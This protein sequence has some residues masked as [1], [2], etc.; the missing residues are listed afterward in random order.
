MT[1]AYAHIIPFA[2]WIILM[3][4]LGWAGLPPTW[5]Y[6]LRT[7]ACA[8][9][10]YKFRPW[11][12]YKKSDFLHLPLSIS[13]GVAVWFLWIFFE[14]DWCPPGLSDFYV[15]WA[16]RPLGEPRPALI[17]GYFDPAVCGW[18]LA[19]VRLAGTALVVPLI[20]EF[21]WRGFLYRW[22]LGGN[23]IDV[24]PGRFDRPRFLLVAVIFGLEHYEWLAGI[25]AGLAYG[26][27]YVR[28]RDI[29]APIVAHAVTNLALGIYVLKTAA[30]Q[31]W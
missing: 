6:A 20:E 26:W 13:V 15:K 9:L 16:V 23:F 14:S 4:V 3:T 31:F 8:G 25:A 5:S 27:L 22:M 2:A 21:F 28:T 29:W 10:L 1:P 18:F 19:L 11:Q 7:L 17:I 30:W 24:D 12:W